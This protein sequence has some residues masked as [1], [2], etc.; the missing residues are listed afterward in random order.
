MQQAPIVK[1]KTGDCCIPQHYLDYEHK[2]ETV[3]K[4]AADCTFDPRFPIFVGEENGALY[5]QVGIVGYDN[6]RK[7][8]KQSK[9]KIVYGRKWRI[10]KNIPTSELVQTIF[11]AI[12][13]AREHEVRELFK[14]NVG[15]KTATP[16]SSHQDLPLMSRHANRLQS[17]HRQKSISVFSKSARMLS[18]KIYFDGHYIRFLHIEKRSGNQ[19]LIEGRL[20]FHEVSQLPENKETSFLLVLE[21]PDINVLFHEL[22]NK[23]IQ[24]SDRYVEELFA[25]KGYRRFSRDTCIQAV[26]ELSLDTRDKGHVKDAEFFHV[27]NAANYANDKTRIPCLGNSDYAKYVVQHLSRFGELEGILPQI[28]VSVRKLRSL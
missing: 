18:D 12:K 1:L 24:R 28:D 20:V 21:K 6:Y 23:F 26:A 15:G 14:L 27:L 4:V 8:S 19:V 3:Q 17:K 2:L 13:K 9:R 11:L 25:Y 22:I 10:E 16:F 5:V 7:I